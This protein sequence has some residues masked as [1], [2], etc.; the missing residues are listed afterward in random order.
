MRTNYAAEE[1]TGIWASRFACVKSE[2]DARLTPGV[3]IGSMVERE[4]LSI[5]RCHTRN[6]D[7]SRCNGA[8]YHVQPSRDFKLTLIVH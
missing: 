3:A 5:E 6:G 2:S 8:E 7:A 4:A 1:M